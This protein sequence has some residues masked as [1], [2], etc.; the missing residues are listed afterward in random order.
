MHEPSPAV[1]P[2]APSPLT[3]AF[4]REA[5]GVFIG[6][7]GARGPWDPEACHGGPVAALLAR[8]LELQV[9]DRVLVR[10]TVELPRPVP[11]AGFTIEA[12]TVRAGRSVAATS[13]A[14]T[15]G[16]GRVCATA[17]GL[18][19]QQADIG[20][21]PSPPQPAPTLSEAV[22]GPFPITA[23]RHPLPMFGTAVEARYPPGED[24]RPGPT[25]LWLRTPAILEGEEP[26]PFQRMCPLADCGNAIS[27]NVE[28]DEATFVNPDLTVFLVRPPRGAW[29]AAQAV[30]HWQPSGIG[31]SDAALFDADGFVGRAVQT[32][33]IRPPAT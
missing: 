7:D 28:L 29:L 14:L 16:A 15:D 8:A 23:A 27:R 11:V 21:V 32:L 17:Y 12:S 19:L 10:L 5:G 6:N 30:S 18:H 20:D 26:S 13:A 9:P 4:F 1:S 25:T 2:A 22:P 33:L 24:R 31:L 3:P